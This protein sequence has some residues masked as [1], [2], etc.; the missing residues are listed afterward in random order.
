M[1]NLVST[2]SVQWLWKYTIMLFYVCAGHWTLV[3]MFI[4][5][6][7]GWLNHLPSPRMHCF[8]FHF[9]CYP[10]YYYSMIYFSILLIMDIFVSS[11]VL[12]KKCCSLILSN[13]F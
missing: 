8:S 12:L 13:V 2:S 3:L 5:Q 1:N 11:L 10:L 7:L 4:Q 6:T 9:Y